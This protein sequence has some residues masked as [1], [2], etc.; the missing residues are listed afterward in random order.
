M[1]HGFSNG[2]LSY[3]SLCRIYHNS[4]K[5]NVT[6]PCKF[7]IMGV[8][9]AISSVNYQFF[10][11]ALLKLCCKESIRMCSH[12]V[13]GLRVLAINGINLSD[14]HKLDSFT[15]YALILNNQYFAMALCLRGG[16]CSEKH[17][18]IIKY[19]FQIGSKET[20][21]CFHK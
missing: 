19:I 17:L 3:H 20:H 10:S 6:R 16:T 15:L 9:P 5:D 12:S 8:K 2:F 14:F 21:Y 13:V 18:S 7:S 4:R 1:L 11:D